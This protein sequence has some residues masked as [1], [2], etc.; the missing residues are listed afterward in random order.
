MTVKAGG[1]MHPVP[2]PML[3]IQFFNVTHSNQYRRI[4]K[5]R[6]DKESPVQ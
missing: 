3:H 5:G 6:S 4:K 1:H 2:S